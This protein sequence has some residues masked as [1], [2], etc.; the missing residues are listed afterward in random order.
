MTE[1]QPLEQF[2]SAKL[3]RERRRKVK[4]SEQHKAYYQKRKAEIKA[5]GKE[6]EVKKK[7]RKCKREYLQRPEVRKNKQDYEKQYN[8]ISVN[9]EK[10]K[11]LALRRQ[12]RKKTIE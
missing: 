5:S 11:A 4:R 10:K 3:E 6:E 7:I 2:V 1:A 12:K 8:Q 9:K